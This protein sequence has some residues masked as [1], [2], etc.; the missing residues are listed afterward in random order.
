MKL[1]IAAI[2]ILFGT[3]TASA[4]TQKTAERAAM[5]RLKGQPDAS[6]TVYEI[7]DFQCP[8]CARFARDVFP[9]IDSAYVKTGKV[10]WIF[11]NFPMPTHANAWTATEAAMCAGGVADKFWPM[12]DKLFI[13]QA[14]WSGVVNPASLFSKYAKELGLGESYEACVADDRMASIV[15]RDIL[16]ASGTGLTGTPAFAVNGEP[17]FTGV[18]PFEEW[19]DI[20][21]AAI[22]KAAAP[23]VK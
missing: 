4:Q 2:L 15:V 1:R 5:G 8:F 3:A 18:R 9:R 13:T 10:K 21:D 19:K 7:A 14:E 23:A 11:V 20:L 17:I 6:V 12:H 16:N 22:R